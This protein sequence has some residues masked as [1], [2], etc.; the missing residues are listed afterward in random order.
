[1]RWRDVSDDS[2][3]MPERY[4]DWFQRAE[5]AIRNLTKQGFEVHRVDIDLK[6][7]LSWAN[8]EKIEITGFARSSFANLKL[9]KREMR[10]LESTD[11]PSATRAEVKRTLKLAKGLDFCEV[12][13]PYLR[14]PKA[15]ICPIFKETRR[16]P[17]QIGS[18]VFVQVGD[19]HFLLTAAHVTD[20]RHT[21]AL[22]VPSKTDFVSLFG[23]FIETNA[24]NRSRNEDK[25][26]VAVVRLADELVDR[27]H[28]NFLFLQHADCDLAETMTAGDAYTV[29]GCPARRSARQ[30]NRVVTDLFSL[31]GEGVTDRRFQQLGLDPGHNVIVQYRMNRAV[32]FS[33]MLKRQFGN[34]EGMSGGG[35]FAWDKELPKLSA[36]KQPKLIAVVT[37]YH[38]HQNVFVGTRLHAYLV[39][40]HR[41]DPSL[42]IQPV[43]NYA[44]KTH[45]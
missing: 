11:P 9:G 38:P 4:D 21:T 33:T 12:W 30:G 18:G 7:F 44:H 28:D 6:E 45:G 36:L 43:S 14:R 17:E 41:N 5:E 42:P 22:L 19:T 26:D 27:L 25:L 37:E 1:M 39:A 13:E 29:I 23:L 16:G 15:S 40:M 20:E 32:D 10:R 24:K 8:E 35:I 2:D 31:S 3:D 34:P